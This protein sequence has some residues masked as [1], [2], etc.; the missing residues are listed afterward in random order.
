MQLV[1]RS[2]DLVNGRDPL[3]SAIATLGGDDF[4]NDDARSTHGDDF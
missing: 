3:P 2:R 4:S 1:A